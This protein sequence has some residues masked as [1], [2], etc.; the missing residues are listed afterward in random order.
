MQPVDD[1]GW[2]NGQARRLHRHC[3]PDHCGPSPGFVMAEAG[4]D[5]FRLCGAGTGVF[6]TPELPVLPSA[7][8]KMH[9]AIFALPTLLC[10]MPSIPRRRNPRPLC[11]QQRQVT[12]ALIVFHLPVT[13]TP[14]HERRTSHLHGNDP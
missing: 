8:E 4:Q 11:H 1:R 6:T 3:L 13:F 5:G 7:L 9:P 2:L 10:L 14:N 12:T